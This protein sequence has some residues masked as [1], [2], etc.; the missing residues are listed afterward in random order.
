MNKHKTWPYVLLAVAGALAIGLGGFVFSE[1]QWKQLSGACIG[2]G[3]AA[4]AIGAG[5]AIL[6]RMLPTP[7]GAAALRH[8]QIEVNDE[9]NVR[10]REKVGATTNQIVFYVLCAVILALGLL[11]VELWVILLLITILALQ[12]V[13]AVTLTNYYSKQI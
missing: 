4:L 1:P 11:G 13:L 6:G 12:G 10:I 3:A 5:N 2:A 7:S 8:K 9:R